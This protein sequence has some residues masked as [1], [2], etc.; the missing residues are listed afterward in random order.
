MAARRLSLV[1]ITLT[2]FTGALSVA[3]DSPLAG[4]ESMIAMRDGVRLY[5]Q[6][7]CYATLSGQLRKLSHTA[8]QLLHCQ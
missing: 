8:R 1:A 7:Y 5:T 6:I 3:Q 4:I 2:C